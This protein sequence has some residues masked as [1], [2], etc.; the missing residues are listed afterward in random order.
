MISTYKKYIYQK[1]LLSFLKVSSVFFILII[2][3]NLFEE[4]R[5]LNETD[6]ILFLPI[7]LTLLNAPSIFFEILPFIILISAI[8]FFIEILD[9]NELVIYKTYGITNLKIIEIITSLTFI[10]GIL[11]VIVFYNISANFKFF[12]LEIKNQYAKDDKYLAV[13]T[14]NGLWIRDQFDKTTNYINAE[15]LENNNLLDVSI[16]QFDENFRLEKI[17]ISKKAEITNKVWLLE[18]VIVSTDNN[19]L[20]YDSY[21]FNSNFDRNKILS[22]FEN[23]TSLNIFKLGDLKNDY[24]LLGY[25]TEVLDGYRHKLYSYPFYLALMVTIASIV[26]LKTQFN[27]SKIFHVAFG[28][29][30]SVLIYY[31]NHFFNVIIETQNIPYLLSIWGPQI[32]ILM[33]VTINLIRINEK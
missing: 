18:D 5:F 11:M 25:N 15:K 23:F 8:F 29:L 7:F 17:I 22:I 4:I 13:V 33:I 14:G 12:Y 10:I 26:M 20:K 28:I 24:E 27:K 32:I 31:I 16:S 6:N 9:S 2:I 3:M 21:E 19:S 30:I 1:Y